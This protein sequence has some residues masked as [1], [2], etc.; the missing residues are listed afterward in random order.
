MVSNY[1]S[2]TMSEPRASSHVY[3][4]IPGTKY[5][6]W[7]I[8]GVLKEAPQKLTHWHTE[9]KAPSHSVEML[10]DGMSFYLYLY[11]ARFK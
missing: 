9:P 8:R 3:G 5:S 11:Y 2:T 6:T 1:S 10:R 7:S 4:L